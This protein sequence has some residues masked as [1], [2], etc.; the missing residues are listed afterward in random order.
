MASHVTELKLNNI[1]VKYGSA[2]LL[3]NL[4]GNFTRGQLNLIVG[5]AG[6]G[7][8]TLLRTIAG[9]HK[10]FS[11]SIMADDKA[12]DPSGNI[13]LVFQNPEAL[14]FNGSVGEEVGYALKMRGVL[15]DEIE[16][17]S[18][19]WLQQW[20][21]DPECCWHRHPLELSGGEKRRLALAACTVFLP[22]VVLLDEPLAGLDVKGQHALADMLKAMA[23]D[24]IVIVVTHEPEALMTDSSSLLYLRSGCGLWFTPETF[25]YQALSESDFF[26]LPHWYSSAVTPFREKPALPRLE[27]GAVHKFIQEWRRADADKL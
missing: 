10:E 4:C 16:C 7:K 15:P 24:H 8:S 1:K 25:L 17:T 21:L 9:F 13:S 23:T 6:S 20:G 14:F 26:P 12:F 11:G 3:D 19:K 5:R 22:P 18:K 27:A 2:T